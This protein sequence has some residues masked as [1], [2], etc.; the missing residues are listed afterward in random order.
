MMRVNQ[1]LI[2]KKYTNRQFFWTFFIPPPLNPLHKMI[3]EW[4]EQNEFHKRSEKSVCDVVVSF[5]CFILFFCGW[6]EKSVD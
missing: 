5:I 2:K 1:S 4:A 6:K 3:F